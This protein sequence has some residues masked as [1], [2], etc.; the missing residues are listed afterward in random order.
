MNYKKDEKIDNI[1]KLIIKLYDNILK[2]FGK[3]E[4]L[5]IDDDYITVNQ[6]NK[7]VKIKHQSD[8][9]NNENICFLF[10]AEVDYNSNI[11]IDNLLAGNII[12]Q[13]KELI[14]EIE[15]NL[16]YVIQPKKQ[17]IS[18]INKMNYFLNEG[19]IIKLGDIKFVINEINISYDIKKKISSEKI[20][21]DKRKRPYVDINL[22]AEPFLSE[23]INIYKQCKL[24]TKTFDIQICE[25]EKKSHFSCFALKNGNDKNNYTK[26]NNDKV[27]KYFIKNFFCDKCNC[28]YS[29]RYRIPDK[30]TILYSVPIDS[31]GRESYMIME[32]IGTKDKTVFF[33]ILSK[34]DII[35]GKNEKT[36]VI[37]D[38]PSIKEQHAKFIFNK[39]TGR[40]RIESLY[41]KKN[42][43]DTSV[44]IRNDITLCEKKILLKVK[45]NV[46]IVNALKS[47][48]IQNE[49]SDSSDD[50]DDDD[51][52]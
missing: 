41:E 8:L 26:T 48:D 28:Q 24:C 12:Y 27:I 7:I 40:V 19:D 38:D 9:E 45:N 22:V 44:L 2:N 23:K 11:H 36:D 46:F 42:D 31:I 6:N 32:S 25:C 15:K 18:R 4:I 5:D 17:G 39:N 16:W 34:G 10:F 43:F 20:K 14:N 35:I 47:E 30:N 21:D 13:N 33:I 37:I 3:R 29:F 1:M 50:D 51:D 49:S 52:E